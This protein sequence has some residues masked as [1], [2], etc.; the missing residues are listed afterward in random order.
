MED[1]PDLA[2]LIEAR[3]SHAVAGLLNEPTTDTT[4]PTAREWLRRWGASG[5]QP[6]PP[7]CAC[8]TGH[9]RICN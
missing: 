1:G 7:T 4:D 6:K 9:C 8:G 3:D 2:D 5:L